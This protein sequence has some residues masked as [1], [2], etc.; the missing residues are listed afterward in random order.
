MGYMKIQRQMVHLPK[1]SGLPPI[2]QDI[3]DECWGFK[4]KGWWR[5]GDIRVKKPK[6]TCQCWVRNKTEVPAGAQESITPALLAPNHNFGKDEYV[7]NLA[8]H[9]ARYCKEPNLA[10]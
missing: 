4:I 5:T 3:Q 10:F 6:K 7:V 8:G 2:H 9:E 1:G